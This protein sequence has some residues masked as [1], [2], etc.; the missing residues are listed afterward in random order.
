MTASGDEL[1]SELCFVLVSTF[2]FAFAVANCRAIFAYSG[3]SLAIGSHL[4]MR[5]GVDLNMPQNGT[6][7]SCP[8]MQYGVNVATFRCSLNPQ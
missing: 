8:L 5:K 1:S 6:S 3:G 2:A 4:D 7:E